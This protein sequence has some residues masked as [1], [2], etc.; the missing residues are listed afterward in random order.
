[1]TSRVT[2]A[3]VAREAGVSTMTVSRVVNEK[4]EISAA[5]RQR[6]LAVI[7]Q[8]GYRPSAIARGLAT[9]R[10]GTLG[11]VVPDISN[12]FFS[13]LARGAE[14]QAYAE[15]YNIFLCNTK[16]DPQR[17]VSTLES[18]AEKRVDGLIVCSSRLEDGQLCAALR[19]HPTVVL[20]NRRL[21]DYG[22]VG[23]VCVDD[24]SG[25]ELATR[26]LLQS[27]HR[28]LGMLAGPPASQSGHLRVQ[29][30]KATLD[31][32]GL[33]CREDWVRPCSSNVDGGRKVARELL[34]E[35]PEITALFC[36]NDLVA[37]GALQACGELGRHV[38]EDVAIV[39]FDDIF[40]A[41]LVTPSLTTCRIPR[42]DLGVMAMEVLLNWIGDCSDGCGDIVLQ[43]ELVV[44][45]SAP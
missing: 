3:D 40:L 6:V 41:A 45:A 33:S 29:G 1:M 37:V 16:E 4:G 5:T 20:V 21:A 13:D 22:G 30:Y 15:G 25:G 43:P 2:M 28:A 14:D 35:S 10:T 42:Y 36:Y 34:L 11:L 23:I 27:G 38:P 8:L 24:A 7:E 17:E 44:R 9:Q 26:H 12:P 18:L 39:G 31:G 32:A 19:H